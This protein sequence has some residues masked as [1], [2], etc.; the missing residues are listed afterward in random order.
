MSRL[1]SLQEMCEEGAI[2]FL[3]DPNSSKV[4][5]LQVLNLGFTI[6]SNR[7]YVSIA[8]HGEIVTD[9]E[10]IESLWTEFA[11]TWFPDGIDSSNLA[12]LKFVPH[13]A[14]FWDA[15]HSKMVRLLATLA[16]MAA[17][18]PI[19]MGEHGTLDSLK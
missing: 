3:T 15:N 6:I 16:S 9:R 17:A 14:E 8:G 18:R 12:L 7:N 1:M 5:H 4:K 13:H 19:G 11:R 2:W 10:R